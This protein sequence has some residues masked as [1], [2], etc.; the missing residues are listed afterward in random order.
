M[1]R[2]GHRPRDVPRVQWWFRA[3][4]RAR[5]GRGDVMGRMR[6]WAAP[7]ALLV[8]G[9]GMVGTAPVMG[10]GP[11]TQLARVGEPWA[12]AFD[13][14]TSSE[15]PLSAPSTTT[16]PAPQGAGSLLLQAE[17]GRYQ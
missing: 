14:A 3:R 15:L 7:L 9:A 16:T 5:G 17:A 13:C 8:A 12:Y 4:G 1:T 11:T 6:A 2:M 10:A